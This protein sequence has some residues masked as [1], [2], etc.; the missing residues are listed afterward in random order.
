MLVWS[1]GTSLTNHVLPAVDDKHQIQTTC[2]THECMYCILQP[3]KEVA[4]FKSQSL[5]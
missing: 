5:F 3:N 2:V 4:K 1:G